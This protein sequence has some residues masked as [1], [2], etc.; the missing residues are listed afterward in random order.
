MILR[1]KIKLNYKR[2]N[3]K[4]SIH[5]NNNPPNMSAAKYTASEAI[6]AA[7]ISLVRSYIL[8]Q[9][10]EDPELDWDKWDEEKAGVAWLKFEL[11]EYS[12]FTDED[13]E[14]CSSVEEVQKKMAEFSTEELKMI[15]SLVL[16]NYS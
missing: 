11:E 7:I 10:E 3:L 1:F 13:W 14:S 16:N 6:A 5:H 2:K 4:Y 15:R 9:M 12:P 8:E